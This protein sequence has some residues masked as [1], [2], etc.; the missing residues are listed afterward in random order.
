LY[1]SQGQERREL[2][3]IGFEAPG[4]FVERAGRAR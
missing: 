2:R 3:L 4:P 1:F